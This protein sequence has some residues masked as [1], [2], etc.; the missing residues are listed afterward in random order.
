M[1]IF[2][3]MLAIAL[4]LPFSAQAQDTVRRMSRDEL[5]AFLPGTKVTHLNKGGSERHWVNNPDGT[6]YANTNNKI[7][8]SPTGTQSAGSAGKWE[9]NELGQYCI[10]IDWKRV[11]EKWCSYIG[12]GDDGSYYLGTSEERRK[13]EFAR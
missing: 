10:H 6:L 13:I 1:R 2:L 7:F 5:Q 3:P 12:K 4:A 9:I 11:D 8:G